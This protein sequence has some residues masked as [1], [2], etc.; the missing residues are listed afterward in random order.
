MR[1][2]MRH[3]WTFVAVT[4]AVLAAP[5]AFAASL[6]TLQA[7]V[8]PGD[9]GA[10]PAFQVEWWY[11]AGTVADQRGRDFFWFA[12]LWSGGG[13]VLA[14]VNV[15][16]LQADRIVLSKEYLGAGALTSGQTRMNVDGFRLGW[17]PAGALGRWWVDA[18]VPGRGRL[19]LTLIPAQP[20]VLNGPDGIVPEGPG[21]FSAY[22]SDPRLAAR[23]TLLL[24]GQ[25][26]RVRGQGWFDHQWGNFATNS[27]SWHWNWFA[28]QFRNGSDLMLYQ[29][30]T[31]TGRSTRVR[32]GTFVSQDGAATH[33]RRFT[34]LP[35]GPAIRPAGATGR[36][37]VS[38]R[39]D[40]PS[41]HVDI[42]LK[43]RARDQFISNQYIPGFWEGAASITSGGSGGCIVESTREPASTF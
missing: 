23:G 27:A 4:L 38:W 14:R 21:A 22:Y 33:P 7:V 3:A 11:T 6:P 28:C 1:V 31:P 41:A 10:H 8:L 40:V 18:P 35:L 30:I 25:P 43:A 16:D 36:Y 39:L 19:Q 17:Q 32:S 24:D 37:P 34:V 9:H 20:Y 15:V 12:T 42:T 26:S 2:G 29:F 5:A 13:F